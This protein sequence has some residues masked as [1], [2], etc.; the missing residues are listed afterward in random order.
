M[1][2]FVTTS[3]A[4]NNGPD[5]ITIDAVGNVY[6]AMYRSVQAWNPAG[7]QLF[8]LSMPTIS[9]TTEDPTNVEFGG[10]DSKT[11]FIT[12]G[13]SLYGIHLNVASLKP[14]DF[15]QDGYLTAADISAMESAMVDLSAYKTAKGFNDSQMTTLGDVNHDTVFNNADLQSLLDKLIAGGGG[16]NPVPEPG[17]LTLLSLACAT[18]LLSRKASA[19]HRR[20]RSG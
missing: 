8:N 7:T 15:N 6:A 18:A 1:R 17:S 9:G 19:I 11:L 3:N 12:A 5:G 16:A 20:R 10:P 2:T 4:G 13:V 14:G